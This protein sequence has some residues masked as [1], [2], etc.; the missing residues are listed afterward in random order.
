MK[1]DIMRQIQLLNRAFACACYIL[2]MKEYKVSTLWQFDPSCYYEEYMECPLVFVKFS[3]FQSLP[4][5]PDGFELC[6]IMD[7]KFSMLFQVYERNLS[8][9]ELLKKMDETVEALSSWAIKLPN[10]RRR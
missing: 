3:G 6:R 5:I 4:S 1:T 8:R 10:N 2:D 9:A 7:E